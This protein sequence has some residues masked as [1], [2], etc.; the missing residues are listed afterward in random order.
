[1]RI[2]VALMVMVVMMQILISSIEI[3]LC[4]MEF[5]VCVCAWLYGIRVNILY[6][7]SYDLWAID[8]IGY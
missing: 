6:I 8:A 7:I 4:V 1:M 5:N 3:E 2:L